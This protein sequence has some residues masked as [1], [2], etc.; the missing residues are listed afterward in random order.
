MKGIV[1]V[2]LLTMAESVAGEE[3]VDEV[4]DA[5]SLESDGAYSSVGNYP[6]AELFQIV[7][8]FSTRLGLP[9]SALQQSFGNWMHG[10]FLDLYPEFFKDKSC[11][12]DM[13][14]AIEN[15]VHV[16]VLK[17]YPDAELPRFETQREGDARLTMI[18]R[19]ERALGFF[20][21]GLIEA[22]LAHFEDE[23]TIT[24]EDY[25]KPGAAHMSFL[26]E[27]Q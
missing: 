24:V 19:S 25:S 15:E 16:E 7:D 4:L 14:E 23:A 26:I 17:L 1:F 6:C 27:H 9:H 18:Y 12:F 13:L 2:E 3:A 11:A 21:M 22:C 8:A 10:R 20:C 5:L